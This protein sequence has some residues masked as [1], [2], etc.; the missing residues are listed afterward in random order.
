MKKF[1]KCIL[2]FALVLNIIPLRLIKAEEGIKTVKV[3]ATIS[4]TLNNGDVT[5]VTGEVYDD[6]SFLIKL[7][8]AEVNA[9]NAT[10]TLRMRN[11]SSLNISGERS[12]SYTINTGVNVQKNL[13]DALVLLGGDNGEHLFGFNDV[14]VAVTVKGDKKNAAATYHVEGSGY[15]AGTGAT[16]TGTVIESAARE[17]W[18]LITDQ[19]TAA[20]KSANDSYII[21]KNG[22]YLQ[23]GTEKLVFEKEGDLKLDNFN[24]VSALASTIRQYLKL[25]TGLE[26]NANVI[27]LKAGTELDVGTSYAKLDTDAL[28]TL[29][30]IDVD[31]YHILSTLRDN[32]TSD[33]RQLIIGAIQF[34]NI[35]LGQVDAAGTLNVEID[36]EYDVEW[37]WAEDCSSAT[38]TF[39]SPV[40]NS[41]VADKMPATITTTVEP[42]CVTAGEYLAKVNYQ[43]A[44]YTD[45]KVGT[46]DPDAHD[47][48]AEFSWTGDDQNGW[49]SDYVLLVCQND[50]TH[51]QG[52]VPT[53]EIVVTDPDCE[54]TGKT[55]YIASAEYDGKTYTETKEVTIP[56]TGH[57]YQFKE[58]EWSE[59]LS[60]AKA[61]FKCKN[62]P[63]HEL[64]KY[65]ATVTHST[66]TKPTC[67]GTGV[68]TYTAVYGTNSETKTKEIPANG[69]TPAEPITEE[70]ELPTCES[71][72]YYDTV[73][74]CNVCGKELSRVSTTIPSEGHLWGTPSY[75]WLDAD[76]NVVTP[77]V[78][79]GTYKVKATSICENDPAH[80][81]TE[82]V[83][84][85]YSVVKP[86]TCAAKG[87]GKYTVSFTNELFDEQTKTVEI[88]K[89]EHE[90]VFNGFVWDGYTAKA[91]YKCVKNGA[92]GHTLEYDATMT[93]EIT[94]E[95]TCE[96][97]GIKTHTA[98]HVDPFTNEIHTMTKDETLPALGHDY[99]AYAWHW[100]DD[101]SSAT[102]ALRCKRVITHTKGLDADV[103]FVTTPATCETD[104][105]TVYTATVEYEGETYT[106]TKTVVLNKLGHEWGEP[107]WV[108]TDEPEVSATVS[109]TCSNATHEGE[110]TVY[111]A[112][113]LLEPVTT[114]ATC[115][116]DG[117]IVYTAKTTFNDVEYTNE[118]TVVLPKT[119]HKDGEIKYVWA[120]D[121][122]TVTATL[123]CANDPS[124]VL[125]TETV[126][127]TVVEKAATGVLPARTIYTAVF[128]NPKFERQI[129]T[130]EHGE[131]LDYKFILQVSSIADGISNAVTATV[132]PNYNADLIIDQGN[133]SMDNAT[134]EVWMKNVASLGVTDPRHHAVA[135]STGLSGQVN[136]TYV[137]NLFSDL[138]S[139]DIVAQVK[140]SNNSVTYHLNNTGWKISA[141][142]DT[143]AASAV[144][145]ELVNSDNVEVEVL[146]TNDSKMEIKKGSYLYIGSK[147]LTVDKDL[148]IDNLNQT[149][150]LIETIKDAVTLRDV[151]AIDHVEIY[152]E[153]G[154]QLTVSS[155]MASLVRDS[156][157]TISVDAESLAK[158]QATLTGL[159]GVSSLENVIKGAFALIKDVCGA[160]DGKTGEN[161]TKV[162]FEFDHVY[163]EP[164]WTWN[165]HKATATFTCVNNP[166]HKVE[167]E[168]T[169]TEARVEPTCTDDGSITYTGKV[170]F[171]GKEYTNVD[172][173]VDTIT[174]LG[175]DDENATVTYVWADDY[176]SCTAYLH[177][178][179]V[180]EHIL[181]T[182]VATVENGKL[183][184]EHKEMTAIEPE[185]TIYR[186]V[187][188]EDARF[189]KQK[190]VINGTETKDY[191]FV[192]Q[193]SSDTADNETGS[194][195]GTVYPDYTADLV[196]YGDK[197]SMSNATI[198]FWMKNV[199][200]LGVSTPRHHQV[201]VNTGLNGEV[202]LEERVVSLFANLHQA[203][204]VAKVKDSNNS[205]TYT[206]TNTEDGRVIN[207]V[208]NSTEF[209]RAVWHEI[210]NSNNV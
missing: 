121:K 47:Y 196:I 4:S 9:S 189:E 73:I 169:V 37:E 3:E 23:L 148:T 203:A 57:D 138:N 86:A 35:L 158:M 161:A 109:F 108:W 84:A 75:E 76:N 33:V 101:Y 62:N 129:E 186:A 26:T 65:D 48:K 68:E 24:D 127:T 32:S 188:T 128:A 92:E 90:F 99:E 106:D 132:Y 125:E 67:E 156:K 198:G 146:T 98:K 2:A 130:V 124:H 78:P 204:I 51:V 131:A 112:V 113:T 194:V 180:A 184:V 70:G 28:I 150:A 183:T 172:E 114:A 210:V 22:S 42:T 19:V 207:A 200:S 36:F 195:T 107:V 154:T 162:V 74:Y 190:V 151:E 179:R 202:S 173:V 168:A 61:V 175:H 136:L 201:T 192:I 149:A 178:G 153:G 143:A 191:K 100:A 159:Q 71:D 187:F 41:V 185:Q 54:A 152:L 164:E 123:Y 81:A 69:H 46:T 55:E 140:G 80:I 110:S 135:I 171:E 15:Q 29:T 126:N 77:S 193:V 167:L 43:G 157:A 17:A 182:E 96:G 141:T 208:P 34:M 11:I 120:E 205:V 44:E 147:K 12:M 111:P 25:E 209:A 97:T 177:C 38:A 88:P 10:V 165:N 49:E 30:G 64:L 155:S 89:L 206:I 163:G 31:D 139:G 13:H 166:D 144:W 117:K 93:A 27:G 145:H 18:M 21:I 5:K 102:V 7:P 91:I 174:K 6:Y 53:N 79:D 58:F 63:T 82:T 133:V 122:S 85:V 50:T 105:S 142:T 104:G 83:D 118:H 95:Q 56:A 170:E 72:G 40:D 160:L 16:I 87:E 45:T 134:I 176:S 103:T 14:D 20:T 115:E 59:D 66:T 199:A 116:V 181:L 52:V 39:R 137:K 60:T 119:G 8:D 1:M 197:V 94:L